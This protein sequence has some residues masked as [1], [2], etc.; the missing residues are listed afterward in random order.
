MN[1]TGMHNTND[2]DETYELGKR[3]GATLSRGACLAMDG[4]LGAGK[5]L[6]VR[7]LVDGL[8]GDVHLVS[9]PTYVLVQEYP[10][11]ISEANDIA[12]VFHL[13]LYRL[14]SP[15]EEFFDLGVDEMLETGVVVIEWGNRAQNELPN[16]H[17]HVHF[18][19]TSETTREITIT[20]Q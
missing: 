1:L 20:P 2:A 18:H 19:I 13:D 14:S 3:L 17:T 12:S 5:T 6:F 4:G 7:G 8:G 10:L 11:E 15:E 16:P 9:S